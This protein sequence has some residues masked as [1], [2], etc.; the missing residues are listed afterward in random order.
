MEA[1]RVVRTGKSIIN[2]PTSLGDK[3][4]LQKTDSRIVRFLANYLPAI[5]AFTNKKLVLLIHR[6]TPL[7]LLPSVSVKMCD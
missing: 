6:L 4:E 3:F 7:S 1:I 5:L 2:I